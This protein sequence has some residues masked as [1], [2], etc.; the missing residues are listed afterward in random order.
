MKK[1]V[2]IILLLCLVCLSCTVYA[3][4]PPATENASVN[5]KFE[6][7]FKSCEIGNKITEDEQWAKLA[8]VKEIAEE[9]WG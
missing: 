7:Y 1:L 8:L 4:E 6:E 3:S 2:S 9:V 5:I